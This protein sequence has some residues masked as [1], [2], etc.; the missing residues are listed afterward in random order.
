MIQK[1]RKVNKRAHSKYQEKQGI[2]AYPRCR[3]VWKEDLQYYSNFSKNT[4]TGRSISHKRQKTVEREE[5]LT[6]SEKEEIAPIP[7]KL[8]NQKKVSPRVNP[9][10]LREY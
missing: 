4:L 7:F 3:R 5:Y 6:F 10:S 2:N 9:F 8:S 1:S